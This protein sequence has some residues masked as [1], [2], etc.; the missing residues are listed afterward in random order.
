LH[1][2]VAQQPPGQFSLLFYDNLYTFARRWKRLA[3]QTTLPMENILPLKALLSS[4]KRIVIAV[5]QRP[6]ADTLGSGLGLATLLKKQQHQVHVIAPT[7]YPIFLDWLPGASE[8]MIFAQ[9]QQEKSFELLKNADVIFCVDFPTL[10]RLHAME[11]VVRKA[12]AA[13]VIIDH[14][15]TTEQFGDLIFRETKAAAT[16]ELLYEIIEALGVQALVD[17]DI[18]ECLYAGIMTD[19][20]SFKN[21][22]TTAKTHCI[23]ASL[24]RH[25]A[26]VARVSKL[27]YE[28]NT[29][30][31]LEFLGFALS[32]RLV[33]LKEYNT[34]YFFIKA[35]DYKRYH[36]QTGDTEGLVN[37]ALSVKGIVFAAVIKEKKDA[38]RL[39]FRSSGAVPVNLWAKEYF[40]GGGHNNAAGGISHL[41]LEETVAK[42]ES[43][44]KAKQNIL[45]P[46]S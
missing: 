39:S 12:A 7:A 28:N 45:N 27:V 15:P 35:E 9:G 11:P 13:K 36:L 29:L 18:A 46:N 42:F 26:D 6:D 40:E 44:V 17:K 24:M 19:T 33:V 2:Q 1:R 25:G 16:A 34:A 41:T 31:K 4:P 14:H 38:I 43:L 5:H 21:P 20:G 22:N 3:L 30:S 37:H 10:N 23:A 8:V 32:H